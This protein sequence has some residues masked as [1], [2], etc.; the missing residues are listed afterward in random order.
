MKVLVTG[1]TGRIGKTLL[2]HKP[3]VVTAEVILDPLDQSVPELPWYRSDICDREKLIMTVTCANPDVVIHLAAATE[4]DDCEREPDMAFMVNRDGA[5]NIAE[6]CDKC[7]AGMLLLSTD[8]VFDGL[9]GPY[10]EEDKP[11]P[12]NVYGCSK[13]EGEHAASS[14][15]GKLMIVRV[16]VPF[17]KRIHGVKHN[18]VSWLIEQLQNGNTVSCA[19]DQFTTPAYLD[20]F[21]QVLW[22]L[23]GKDIS[24]IIHYGTSDRLSRYEIALHVCRTMG[25]SDDLVRPV[26][27]SDLNFTAKRPLESGFITDKV[28]RILDKP[29]I[30]FDDALL[31]IN[32][33]LKL[34]K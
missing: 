19:N 11:N 12:L 18:F 2:L 29:P 4:V 30:S 5:A 25:F 33:E 10:T 14:L 8:Y 24:G 1:S 28:H 31:R 17:G 6:A 13:L 27:T 7:G 20:E 34:L 22:T 15:V 32:N 26:K 3:S 9:L 16:S 23:V 21:S